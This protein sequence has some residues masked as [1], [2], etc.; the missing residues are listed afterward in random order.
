MNTT[1]KNTRV[2]GFVL[3]F[4]A[5]LFWGATSPIAQYLFQSKGIAA[6][7]MVPYR[8]FT[9]GSLLLIYSSVKKMDVKIVWKQAKD[10]IRLI[11]FAVFGM[12][13]MQYSFFCAVEETNAG[14]A[15][16]FQYLNPAL[17]IIYFAIVHKIMPKKKELVAV[18]CSLVGIFLVATHGNLNE[19]VISPKGLLFGL[20]LA[21]ATCCYGVI[22][23]PL[24]KKYP[25]E[26]VCGWAMVMGGLVLSLITRP[27]QIETHIDMA[28]VIGFMTIV[29]LGTILP[30]CFYLNSLKHISSVYA[31]LLSAVEPVA[32]PIVAAI[33][34]GTKF[35]TID[36]AGFAL[37]LS[38]MFILNIGNNKPN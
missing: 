37:V 29:I 2:R 8:L 4:L 32:A 36:V 24:L 21:L 35:Q 10:S 15:T 9:A 22:P 11:I 33:F 30:F 14:V 3:A 26:V 34:L 12:M 5:G 38:T 23:V 6:S 19:L 20:I 17:L 7:W 18:F 28:V 13:G 25:A 1:T 31:G 16:I 27:W